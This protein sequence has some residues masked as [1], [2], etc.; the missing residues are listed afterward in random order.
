MENETL[1]ESSFSATINAPMEKIDI[2][3]WCFS[4]PEAGKVSHA[5]R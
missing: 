2:P 1:V 4:L 3:E 5:V